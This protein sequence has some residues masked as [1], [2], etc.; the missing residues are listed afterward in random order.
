MIRFLLLGGRFGPVPWTILTALGGSFLGA[1]ALFAL[2]YPLWSTYFPVGLIV[3]GGLVTVGL[4]L[5]AV[6]AHR[7]RRDPAQT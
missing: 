7:R 2:L 4:A 1:A 3:V 6:G 5:L